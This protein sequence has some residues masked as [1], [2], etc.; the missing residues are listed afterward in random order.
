MIGSDDVA[1]SNSRQL[2]LG[3][4]KPSTVRESEVRCAST[5]LLSCLGAKTRQ[6]GLFQLV[7]KASS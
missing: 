5:S 4:R 3:P 1:V 7:K 2:A 6:G